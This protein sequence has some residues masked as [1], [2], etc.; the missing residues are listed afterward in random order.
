MKLGITGGI[1]SGKTSVCRIFSVLGI[2]VFFADPEA[3]LIMSTDKK[4]ITGINEIAGRNIYPEGKLDR[5]LLASLIFND[6]ESLRKV[7]SLV[8]PVVFDKFLKWAEEQDSPYVIMEAAILFESGASELVDRVATVYA[9][10][11]ER[12]GRVTRRNKLTRE[13]VLQRMK[14]QLD[15]EEK[16]RMSDYVINNSEND[17]II[18][19]I[20]KI[21]EDL[22]THLNS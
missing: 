11:E 4:V 7:N 6:A 5:E 8:H 14:N 19:V 20:L 12:I 22:I 2:P 9:P 13:Q 3:S 15:D 17:M 10:V 16:I 18:P 21:H 1:G